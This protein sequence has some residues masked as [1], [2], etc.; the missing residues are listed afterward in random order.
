M[1][2][3]SGVLPDPEVP[4]G[5]SLFCL[6]FL[7]GHVHVIGILQLVLVVTVSSLQ[8]GEQ[9]LGVNTTPY[10]NRYNNNV[11]QEGKVTR[12]RGENRTSNNNRYYTNVVREGKLTHA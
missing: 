10:N 5:D 11:I 4:D 8:E 7:P 9:M 2:Y 6:E 3:F 1:T 12:A